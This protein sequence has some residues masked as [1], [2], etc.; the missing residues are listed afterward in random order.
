MPRNQVA[1]VSLTLSPGIRNGYFLPGP[2]LLRSPADHQSAGP[3]PTTFKSWFKAV[4]AT[5]ACGERREGEGGGR[6]GGR[7]IFV[8]VFE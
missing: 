2:L 7:E 6:E 1:E 4:V 3:Y 5:L 8:S